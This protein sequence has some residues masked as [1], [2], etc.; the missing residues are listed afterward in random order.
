VEEQDKGFFGEIFYSFYQESNHTGQLS[1]IWAAIPLYRWL[2]NYPGLSFRASKGPPHIPQKARIV[3]TIRN[4]PWSCDD[5][6]PIELA[7][8]PCLRLS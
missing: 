6:I 4:R 2:S 3:Y 5:D 1:A 7:C 8:K